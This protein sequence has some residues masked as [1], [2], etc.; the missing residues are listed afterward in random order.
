MKQ[1]VLIVLCL[2]ACRDRRR[3]DVD[4]PAPAPTRRVDGPSRAAPPPRVVRV[5]G[6]RVLGRDGGCQLRKS[7]VQRAWTTV[8]DFG[9]DY[10]PISCEQWRACVTAGICRR[11]DGDDPQ[12]YCSDSAVEVERSDAEAFCRWRGGRL[13]AWNEWHRAL[14]GDRDDEQAQP[15]ICRHTRGRVG[16]LEG[17]QPCQFESPQG[18]L[19]EFNNFY[20]PHHSEWTSLV[21]CGMATAV[22]ED[23]LEFDQP[24]SPLVSDFR[25]AYD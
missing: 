3:N 16:A 11:C 15:A 1:V 24:T 6:G 7:Y 17:R 2:A 9:I 10:A 20:T 18:V 19:F 4:L 13:P 14:R 8:A 12:C 25:C 23:S 21:D 5:Q 22:N